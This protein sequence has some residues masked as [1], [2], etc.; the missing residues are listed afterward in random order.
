MYILPNTT[1]TRKFTDLM[2]DYWSEIS[3]PFPGN[4]GP[5]KPLGFV[6]LDTEQE[7]EAIYADKQL[8]IP[9]ELAV[10]FDGNPFVDM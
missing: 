8:A 5:F 3:W 7:L 9:V 1:E 10:V 6:F 4:G 2:Q